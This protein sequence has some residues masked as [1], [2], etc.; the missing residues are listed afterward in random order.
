MNKKELKA[1]LAS[2]NIVDLC[3]IILGDWLLNPDEDLRNSDI[4][5]LLD[6]IAKNSDDDIG[7]AADIM[8]EIQQWLQGGPGEG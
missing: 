2:K 7:D 8:A 4:L 5:R 1:A 3:W 6:I